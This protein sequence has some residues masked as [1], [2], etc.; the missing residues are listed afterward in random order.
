MGLCVVAAAVAAVVWIP[1]QIDPRRHT[2]PPD[3][4]RFQPTLPDY[5]PT[6]FP[7]Q[8]AAA[9]GPTPWRA[10]DP[11][12]LQ[13]VHR[14]CQEHPWVADVK[15]VQLLAGP[16]ISVELTFHEP[17]LEVASA[18]GF[19]PVDAR[20]RR[21]PEIKPGATIMMRLFGITAPPPAVGHIWSREVERAAAVA[22][23]LGPF[24]NLLGLARFEVMRDPVQ[25]VLALRTTRST[26]I[27]WSNL[28]EPADRE[29]NDLQKLQRLRDYR[30]Q[31]G[32]LDLPDGP[33][34][35]D[36][37]PPDTMT[38]QPLNLSGKE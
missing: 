20:G 5:L 33:Y 31:F 30:S 12:L 8:V 26:L 13:R 24:W 15:R 25:P 6:N 14:A 27:V 10:D 17:V 4:L 38:R 34:R 21:L 22:Q 18:G 1:W 11:L 37:R 36:V 28:P 19:V 35:L 23:P 32:S 3:R 29:P 7:A 2:I 16:M 9:V